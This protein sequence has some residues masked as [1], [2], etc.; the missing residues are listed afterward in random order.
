MMTIG[1]DLR[2]LITVVAM[3]GVIAACGEDDESENGG[4]IDDVVSNP[5]PTAPAPSNRAPTIGGAPP[6]SVMAGASFSFTPTASDPDGDSLTFSINNRPGWIESFD[7]A[8]GT[9]S[10]VPGQGDVGTYSNIV[11]TVSDG[12]LSD[13]LSPF[14]VAVVQT[15]SGS[16]ELSWTAPT[17]NTDGSPLTDLTGYAFYYGTSSGSY[18]NRIQVN[19]PGLTSYVIDELTPDTYYFV[20][21]AITSG[22]VESEYSA[23]A[24]KRVM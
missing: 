7:P 13:S 1:R 18:P 17:L 5:P 11:I 14:S 2:K 15:S 23:E 20:A 24:V 9:I 10:G 21:V 19:D 4:F 6:S 12:S 3:C 22:N 8:T 16:V